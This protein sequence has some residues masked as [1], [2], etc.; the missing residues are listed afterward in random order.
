M[1]INDGEEGGFWKFPSLRSALE[2]WC[3]ADEVSLPHLAERDLI[4]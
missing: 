1:I 2:A 4:Q 3:G